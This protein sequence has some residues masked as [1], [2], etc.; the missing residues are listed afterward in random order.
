M[1]ASEGNTITEK[2]MD[3]GRMCHSVTLYLD[4]DGVRHSSGLSPAPVVPTDQDLPD[5][6]LGGD[7]AFYCVVFDEDLT[8]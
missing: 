1:T 7:Y 5:Q 3:R 4:E 8:A 2:A 6:V